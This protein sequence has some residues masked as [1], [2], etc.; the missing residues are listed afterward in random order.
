M[1]KKKNYL[2][3]IW[4]VAYPLILY[5]VISMIVSF[6]YIFQ[7]TVEVINDVGM[8][9]A[10][11]PELVAERIYDNTL[12]ILLVSAI[13]TIPIALF[14]MSRDKKKKEKAYG[15]VVV[16]RA[17]VKDWV[18]ILVVAI[19]YCI[20]A[21]LLINAL[22]LTKLFGGYEE[23]APVIYSSTFLMQ[24]IT[25]GIAAPVV[26]ELLFRGLAHRR[27]EEYASFK[28]AMVV[29]A[30]LFAIYHMNVVQGVYAFGFGLIASYVMNKFK[31]IWAPI[32]F[33]CG[34]NI[35]SII[36]T[37]FEIL[38]FTDNQ[39]ILQW[40][41]AFIFLIGLYFLIRMIKTMNLQETILCEEGIV[42]NEFNVNNNEN[43]TNESADIEDKKE[44][45]TDVVQEDEI[46]KIKNNE[47]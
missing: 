15:I 19:F 23:V 41:I 13:V 32:L 34:A 47:K 6:I 7:F 3:G 30:L 10:Y 11:M 22:N 5:F 18:L 45:S 21:N 40:I 37:K 16:E 17:S 24:L 20:G 25:V 39:V 36:I 46:D 35:M 26:E 43:I 12:F 8:N 4:R 29:S 2:M 27:I 44:K 33:H 1:K 31:T 38:S 14:L 42:S 9:S 28:V